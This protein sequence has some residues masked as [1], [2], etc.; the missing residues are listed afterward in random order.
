M[1]YIYVYMYYYNA[2]VYMYYCILYNQ[3]V[4]AKSNPNFHRFVLAKPIYCGKFLSTHYLLFD[5]DR[6]SRVIIPL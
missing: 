4:F 2:L 3:A 6:F 1:C 5:K